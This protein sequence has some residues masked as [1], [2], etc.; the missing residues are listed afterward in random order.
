MARPQI[1]TRFPANVLGGFERTA[2]ATYFNL[3]ELQV[4][5]GGG[6]VLMGQVYTYVH[7]QD[8]GNRGWAGPSH[9]RTRHTQT[10][11]H[12]CRTA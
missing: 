9:H 7:A 4:R 12:G 1:E 10:P 11:M 5:Q 6:P 2:G 8:L 3:S